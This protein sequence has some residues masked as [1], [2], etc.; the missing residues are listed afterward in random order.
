MQLRCIGG[1][2]P[3]GAF[4]PPNHDAKT[5][6]ATMRLAGDSVVIRLDDSK[7]PDYWQ[8]VVVSVAELIA[9]L[10]E[11]GPDAQGDQPGVD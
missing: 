8:E 2:Y 1:R 3:A 10:S 6:C 9:W 11:V 4:F 5:I 7:H